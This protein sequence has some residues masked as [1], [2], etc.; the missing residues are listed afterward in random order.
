MAQRAANLGKLSGIAGVRYTIEFGKR[1]TEMNLR[2][3]PDA[4]TAKGVDALLIDRAKRE[5]G[6]VADFL[7]IP[8]L[9]GSLSFLTP[10]A[11]ETSSVK[12]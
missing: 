3:L 11:K 2:E 5:A 12:P 4:I 1:I 9:R 8:Y 10:T 6:T 7:G